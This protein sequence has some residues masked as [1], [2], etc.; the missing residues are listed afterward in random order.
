[1]KFLNS[2][3]ALLDRL[4][5]PELRR[6]EMRDLFRVRF[7]AFAILFLIPCGFIPLFS[8]QVRESTHSTALGLVNLVVCLILLG[9]LRRQQRYGPLAAFFVLWIHAFFI[10][11][12]AAT[13]SL[14]SLVYLWSSYLIVISCFLFG[15]RGAFLA[16]FG[17]IASSVLNILYR[18]HEGSPWLAM[19]QNEYIIQI[20]LQLTASTLLTAAATGVYE[21]LR[22]VSDQHQTRQRLLTAR[23]AHTGAVGEL[24][25]HVAHEVNNPLA[26]L[27]G[28]VTRLRRQLERNEW[29]HEARKLLSNMHRSHERII[30]VQQSLAI[31][32][33]GNQHEPFVN[34]D[35][36]SI[37]KDVQ[38][39]MKPQAQAQ[40]VDLDF[41]DQA[42]GSTL[43]CQPHQLVYVLC[44]LIQN[45]LDACREHANPRIVV[46]VQVIDALLHFSVTDNGRGIDPASQERVFQPFFTTKSGGH[47]QGLSLSVSRGILSRHG[48]EIQFSSQPGATRFT[49]MIPRDHLTLQRLRKGA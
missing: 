42:A 38:L 46:D 48:G 34:V 29:S 23:H 16:S 11:M 12:V 41:N 30:R 18:H 26:I 37:L 45:A 21:Y 3:V 9:S 22:D 28:S 44:C 24:V 31:F 25:G 15:L 47:A 40:Q 10:F 27:Q 49:C 6:M 19:T 35:V 13:P 7:L 1:M 4:L 32:A 43:R 36:R 17:V 8:S 33:S 14:F 39:A 2:I 20:F 5:S